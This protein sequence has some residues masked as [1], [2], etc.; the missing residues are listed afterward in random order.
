M[1][2]IPLVVFDIY[3]HRLGTGGGYYDRTFAFLRHQTNKKPLLAGVGYA[4]QQAELVPTD[5]WDVNL[6]VVVT[7]NKLLYCET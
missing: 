5:P 2:V 4:L 6:Q 3:G 1:V 7:E